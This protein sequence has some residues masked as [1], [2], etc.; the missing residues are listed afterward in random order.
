MIYLDQN[1]IYLLYFL[2]CT[3]I[4]SQPDILNLV[5]HKHIP[6]NRYD[7]C[8][9]IKSPVFEHGK[10]ITG[11]YCK[12]DLGS[13]FRNYNG[14]EEVMSSILYPSMIN[15]S[16]FDNSIDLDYTIKMIK[17]FK[18]D[19]AQSALNSLGFCLPK[20]CEPREITQLMNT[21]K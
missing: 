16:L 20:N 2:P 5:L 9:S 15:N 3:V 13:V 6:H 19:L 1:K 4:S 8:L 12:L 17:F 10:Y 21:C 18:T 7:E 11:Q 14:D